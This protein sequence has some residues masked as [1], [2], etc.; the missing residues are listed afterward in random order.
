MK[1]RTISTC[2]P[3]AVA[4]SAHIV[5]C[6]AMTIVATICA[7]PPAPKARSPTLLNPAC[8][9]S[10]PMAEARQSLKIRLAP[11]RARPSP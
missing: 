9:A 4:L 5:A 10:M 1:R 2:R 8:K 7:S 11:P 3:G 6:L